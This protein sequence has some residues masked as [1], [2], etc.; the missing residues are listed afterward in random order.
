MNNPPLRNTFRSSI[1]PENVWTYLPMLIVYGI[2][3]TAL[4]V[5]KI[6][7]SL[8]PWSSAYVVLAMALYI[9]IKGMTIVDD[10]WI[11]R[12]GTVP[13]SLLAEQKMQAEE[14]AK[15]TVGTYAPVLILT[16]W[17]AYG[18]IFCCGKGKAKLMLVPELFSNAAS[19]LVFVLVAITYLPGRFITIPVALTTSLL[20]LLISLFV[21]G[22]D[23]VASTAHVLVLLHKITAF[24]LLY[25]L[26][27]MD[28]KLESLAL[29]H[30]YSS[31]YVRKFT[32]T[33]WILFAG[34]FISVLGW[35]QVAWLIWTIQQRNNSTRWFLKTGKAKA[36][37]DR[38]IKA[39]NDLE[40][41]T[42]NLS[43]S[44]GNLTFPASN[45]PK[46]DPSQHSV[47]NRNFPHHNPHTPFQSVTTYVA[48]QPHP[49]YPTG[50]YQQSAPPAFSGNTDDSRG[51]GMMGSLVSPANRNVG[52]G[53]KT[54]RGGQIAVRGQ[55]YNATKPAPRSVVSL[56]L[57]G[58]FDQ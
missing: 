36:E 56:P 35:A 4:L 49:S 40:T 41:S 38:N 30:S 42:S 2:S 12:D 54:S 31:S 43:M 18:L 17:L 7:I 10:W 34:R 48:S 33:A 32:Q 46:F 29:R 21:P 53:A 26:T 39:E 24:F 55:P 16:F 6:G 47:N 13:S 58:S 1:D 11:S 23:S 28:S 50:G 19:A 45:T 52:R 20:A 22:V 57:G 25:F 14:R 27:E 9:L 3:I 51:G 8:Y 44:N 15:Q 37:S 5:Y